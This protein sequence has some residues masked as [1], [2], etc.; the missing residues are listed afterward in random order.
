MN[1]SKYPL[2]KI[3]LP[4][5][6][7]ILVACFCNFSGKIIPFLFVAIA[8]LW[9]MM[10]LMLRLKHYKWQWMKTV[11]MALAFTFA[12]ICA[13]TL[14]M[15]PRI[16]PEQR[17]A[18]RENHGFLVRVTDFPVPRA[19]SDKVVVELLQAA[20]GTPLKE[21]ALLYVQ[22]D[23]AAPLHY[24]DVLAI[25]TT[26][27]EFAPPANPDA[28]DMRRYMQR[29]GIFLTGYVPRGNWQLLD[30]VHP[31]AMKAFSHALQQRLAACYVNVGM[32]G[33]ELGI[34][35][36]ILL[37]DDDTMEPE[38]RA[39]YASA[40]VS[41]ILCVSGMHVGIIFMIL[42]FLLKPM[43]L[44][45][46]TRV[47]KALLLMLSIWL[48]ANIT[49]LSPSVT[50]SATMFTFVT[51]GGVLR[52]NTNIFHSLMASLFILLAIKPL[53]LFEVGFQLSY[54][55][56][57]GIVL[58]QPR[59]AGLY[60]CKTKV[61]NYF[62]ELLSVSVAAQIATFPI[63]AHYFG[64][65]P[66]YFMLSNLTVIALSFVVMVTGAGL[67]AV[68][69][70]PFVSHGI[71]FLLTWE[72]RIMNAIV[73]FVEGLP[74]AVTRDIDLSGGQVLLLYAVIAMAYC[75]I[76]YRKHIYG[77]AALSALALLSGTFALR[78]VAIERRM[79][80]VTYNI[81]KV[82]A[83]EFCYGGEC[84]LFSDSIC[85]AGSPHYTYSIQNHARKLHARWTFVP[86]DTL[87]YDTPFLVKR[88]PFIQFGDKCYYLL[89][90]R[91]KVLPV[92]CRPR[93]DMLLL[94]HNPTMR[95]EEVASALDFAAV[96]ADET[97]T[98]FYKERW[99]KY[100]EEREIL[101]EA[102]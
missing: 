88:G 94:Q 77:W 62:W 59:I 32:T 61:G 73:T 90:K 66:N 6:V 83:L 69:F 38:L 43:D 87:C 58:I 44:F 56:V 97:N 81:R 30:N 64:T 55:A 4:Y 75:A 28:F 102:R 20:A 49:G 16:L 48:Y 65:F 2:L 15:S 27:S 67:L 63:S 37:G 33:R 46:G 24:G 80:M 71:A 9:L 72:I 98:P 78:R 1:L 22:K 51:I 60:T 11:T 36:A 89:K 50:R 42:N 12:G 91:E 99:R 74:G 45:P 54:F 17:A 76:C 86:I 82:S 7:G 79:E 95:P 96:T 34:V 18:A 23:S 8:F 35:R 93:I 41:H 70:V 84:L 25:S 68:S 31:N 19:N 52:R 3:L 101:F 100:C 29:K 14:R 26:L 57:F 85:D 92:E 10:L 21:K 39:A 40:G 13:T 53:L 5:V 47:A